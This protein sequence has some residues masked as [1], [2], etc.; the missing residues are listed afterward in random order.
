MTRARRPRYIAITSE[1]RWDESVKEH[2]LIMSA[3]ELRDSRYAGELVFRHVL[4]TGQ[5]FIASMRTDAR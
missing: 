1:E 4:K 5:A 3:M 2:E